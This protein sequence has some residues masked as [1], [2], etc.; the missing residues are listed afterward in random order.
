MTAT[1]SPYLD[2]A[3]ELKARVR[4]L[5]PDIERDRR[6]PPSL[7]ED[8]LRAGFFHMLVP[9]DLGGHEVDPVT[10]A[11]LVEEIA[12]ADGSA[13]GSCCASCATSAV[14]RNS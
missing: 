14:A 2:A 4:E 5:A 13:S 7:V 3:R 10:V 12:S 9:R 8:F 11:R 6:L 1:I